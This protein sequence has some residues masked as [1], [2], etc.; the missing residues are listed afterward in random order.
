M[1]HSESNRSR[2]GKIAELKGPESTR[3]LLQMEAAHSQLT[4]YRSTASDP[5]QCTTVEFNGAKSQSA[6]SGSGW[7][8]IHLPT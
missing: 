7:C 5:G 3:L 8:R 4:V 6:A 1:K 2:R